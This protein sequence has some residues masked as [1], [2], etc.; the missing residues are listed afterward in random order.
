M[1]TIKR[2][3]V[4]P[5]DFADLDA[6]WVEWS[7]GE[8]MFVI[9]VLKDPAEIKEV[10][11]VFLNNQLAEHMVG[12]VS[13]AQIGFLYDGIL[14]GILGTDWVEVELGNQVL[15]LQADRKDGA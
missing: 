5:T 6:G 11:R 7:D 15:Q 10:E 14:T 8:E 13:L 2:F 9:D 3:W 1:R 12:L 4:E